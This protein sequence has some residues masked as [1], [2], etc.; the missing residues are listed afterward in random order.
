MLSSCDLNH[1]VMKFE[2]MKPAPPVTNSMRENPRE[3]RR[4]LKR[5]RQTH[6][7]VEQSILS[8]TSQAG[9]EPPSWNIFSS[10]ARPVKCV[11]PL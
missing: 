11:S 7:N 6:Y 1:S 10:T 3:E 5:V 9:K 8:A 2:P 4:L